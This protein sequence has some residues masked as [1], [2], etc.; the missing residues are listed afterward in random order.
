MEQHNR[1]KLKRNV[2]CVL[3]LGFF[4]VFL[5]I[6]PVIVPFFQSRGLDM[7]DVFVLQAVFALVVLLME[8]PSGY[9]ADVL[10]RRR[11]LLVGT[12]FMALGHACLIV[13]DGFAT[14]ALFEALLGVGVSLVSG[15]DL[16]ILYDTEQALAGNSDHPEKV[17]GRLF[18]LHTAGEAIA[19]VVCSLV[20]LVSLEHVVWVQVAVGF[21][22][23]VLALAIVEPPGERLARRDHVGNMREIL[24][25][26]L[27]GDVV[28]RYT[29][30][31]LSVWSLTTFYAVWLLQKQW[32][33]QGIELQHFGYIW[34][35]LMLVSAFAGRIAHRAEK[36]LGTTGLLTVVGLAPAFGYLGLGYLGAAGG[37]AA[38]AL[39]FVS[40]GFGMVVL[41]DA[42]NR[43]L[44]GRFR[45]TANSLASFGFRGA[46]AVTAPLVGGALDG[47]GMQA[48][49][50]LLAAGTIGVFATL[51]VPL[52]GAVRTARPASPVQGV[53]G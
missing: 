15:A 4:Q 31:A 12:I 1:R 23:V 35:V 24:R 22:P 20:L 44:P 25:Y 42:F 13:A 41:R 53:P 26:L 46:F 33:V 7:Q 47:W 18:S 34:G 16:A 19:S 8:L 38:S 10:G 2:V 28:L 29:F 49:L 43:R 36:R 11:A 30:L 52:I 5:V 39:F 37:L 51:I 6:M 3:A 48:T 32:Q 40:R 21:V 9:I 50:V 17:V 45:A 27:A 14:L